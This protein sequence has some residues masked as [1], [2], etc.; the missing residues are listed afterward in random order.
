MFS[1]GPEMLR[2]VEARPDRV[3]LMWIPAAT[4]GRIVRYEVF[5]AGNNPQM[6]TMVGQTPMGNFTDNNVQRGTTYFYY[7]A[8]VD[9]M[10]NYSPVSNMIS[11]AVPF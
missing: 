11:V 1:R 5:R 9:A 8:A 7:V 3:V 2:V 10:G 6:F 4:S